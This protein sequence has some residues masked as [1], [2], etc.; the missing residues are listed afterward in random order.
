MMSCKDC[1]S[2]N[3]IESYGE[4]CMVCTDCGLVAEPLLIDTRPYV[5]TRRFSHSNI[6]FSSPYGTD[7]Q[8]GHALDKLCI[9]YTNLAYDITNIV[10]QYIED[11][12]FTGHQTPLKAFLTYDTLKK[13]NI[14]T[15]S[16]DMVCEAYDI[17]IEKVV[18]FQSKSSTVLQPKSNIK[19]R[20]MSFAMIHC[21]DLKLRMKVLEHVEEIENIV[22]RTSHFKTKKPSR[23]DISIFYY[24]MT[25]TF[26]YKLSMKDFDISI[27]TLKKN[28]K[29]IENILK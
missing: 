21:V 11:N 10:K 2:A 13:R 24:V 18:K 4:G 7:K 28:I 22:M 16:L 14:L 25:N 5:D 3:I 29:L 6:Q 12:A 15:I 8:I 1:G 27:G 19:Q 9:E 23:I 17:D 26:K 20:L